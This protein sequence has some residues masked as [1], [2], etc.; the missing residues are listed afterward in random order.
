MSEE[1]EGSDWYTGV[2]KEIAVMT[3]ETRVTLDGETEPLL[4]ERGGNYESHFGVIMAAI[5]LGNQVS[6]G[7][8]ARTR[9]IKYTKMIAVR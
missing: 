3:V 4:L 2:V 7:C 6:F 9:R 8:P 5:A 1:R